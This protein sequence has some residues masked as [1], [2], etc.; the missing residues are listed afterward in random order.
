L[1]KILLII[2]DGLADRPIKE[3]GNKTPLQVAKMPNF[4]NL[5]QRAVLGTHYALP[6]ED[7]YPTSDE[8]HFEILGY[9]FR[10]YLPGRG[11]LEALG[12]GIDLGKRELALRVNFGTVDEDLMVLDPRAGN[13][14]DV[15]SLV[16]A[17]KEERLGDFT[18]RLYPGLL[19][20]AV[21]VMSGPAISREIHHHSTIVSDTDPHKAKN[22]RGGDKVLQ[23][24]PIDK[25]PEA[26][27]TADALWQ[28]Q[29][30][31]YGILDNNVENKVRRRQGLLPANF[32][33]TRGAGFIDS[34]PP[35]TKK[36]SLSAACVAGG[37]LYKG[38]GRYLGMDTI[39]IP[40]ATADE[41]TDIDAKLKKSLALLKSGYD[42]V[43]MHVKGPDLISEETGDWEKEIEFF[44]RLDKSFAPLAK[45]T[46]V[47]CI[48]GDH[49]TPCTL[50]DHS[51]D[52]VPIMIIG[53]E[54]D[55]IA[56]FDE[57]TV[58]EGSLGHL[59]G[60]EIMPRLI[61]E[62]KRA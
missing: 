27:R 7:D 44:E 5:A 11:V 12:L 51:N 56:K 31:T 35:F 3:L 48:T 10:T 14:K 47:L 9:D 26:A 38:I 33:L 46:G 45:Y 30:K 23:P 29:L 62:A 20:R 22:H 55:G 13:I 17:I 41:H 15:R 25:S 49:A 6:P 40:G 54:K 16:E 53:G 43:F 8:A 24:A 18:F 4:N 37:H 19:H 60:K 32:L 58:R 1:K 59:Q 21:L 2:L 34:V 42:F 57:E 50:K 28:Y 52:P 39:D 61:K 36:Y